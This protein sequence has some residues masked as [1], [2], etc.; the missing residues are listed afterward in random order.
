MIWVLVELG[1]VIALF[2][3]HLMTK[4]WNVFCLY[5]SLLL[6]GY[7]FTERK[8]IAQEWKFFREHPRQWLA[9]VWKDW[10]ESLLVAGILALAIRTF[11][12][13]PY[14]IPTGSMI[15]TFLVGDRIFV[16]KLSYHFKA[17][18]RGDIIVFKYPED[19]KK[20]FHFMI[21]GQD[22]HLDWDTR[23]DFVKRLVGLP[24]DKIEIRDGK[25]FVNDEELNV[26]PFSNNYY[27]NTPDW[28]Y[29]REG[30]VFEVPAKSYF[31]LGDNSAHSSDSRA[32]GF[33]PKENMVGRAFFIFWP[34][35]RVKL[36]R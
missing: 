1:F 34:P 32:W 3:T 8:K 33:V 13:G 31:A 7:L 19:K 20:E 21:A 15:P 22:F 12:V 24:G 14:K 2:V 30:Q 11:L 28:P 16:D 36:A 25:L 6:A 9:Q 29:G 17:P 23:K 5:A 27:Y 26:P 10:G 35:N 18:Q 4:Q